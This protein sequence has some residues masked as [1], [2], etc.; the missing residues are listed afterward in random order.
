M[1]VQLV[2]QLLDRSSAAA[3]ADADDDVC[4]M[5]VCHV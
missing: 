2:V 5:D 4:C 3:A 1:Y